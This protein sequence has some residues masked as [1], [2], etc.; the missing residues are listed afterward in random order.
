MRDRTRGERGEGACGSVRVTS[1]DIGFELPL[2]PGG[3]CDKGALLLRAE[4]VAAAT[5][6]VGLAEED[7]AE[8]VD[9]PHHTSGLRVEG[10]LVDGRHAAVVAHGENDRAGGG[11]GGRDS[12]AE[13]DVRV[14][15]GEGQEGEDQTEGEE[16]GP[17]H[18]DDDG[19]G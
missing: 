11:G 2:G 1:F 18:G 3:G 4:P 19:D 16:E 5:D 13:G 9:G 15:H 12:G 10:P 14:G 17:T 8:D 6:G 7:V